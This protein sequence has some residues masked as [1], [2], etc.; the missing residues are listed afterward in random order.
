MRTCFSF[1][2]YQVEG[3][4]QMKL[5]LRVTPVVQA[6]PKLRSLCNFQQGDILGGMHHARLNEVAFPRLGRD[7]VKERLHPAL[8]TGLVEL[9]RAHGALEPQ[10]QAGIGTCRLHIPEGRF[11]KGVVALLRGFIVR[12]HMQG[13]AAFDGE[14]FDQHRKLRSIPLEGGF[15]HH[16]LQIGLH[17]IT[18]GIA[19][20]PAFAGHGIYKAQVCQFVFYGAPGHFLHI[21][22]EFHGREFFVFHRPKLLISHAKVRKNPHYFSY[23]CEICF[24]ERCFLP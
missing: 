19:F 12:I 8:H 3:L 16:A 15:S 11:A 9:L 2:V 5:A 14:A 13:T 6:E 10:V 4:F 20:E 1:E 24:I 23:I 22:Q 21:R 18:E 17:N 7:A